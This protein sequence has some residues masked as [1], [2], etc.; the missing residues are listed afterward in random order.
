M[1]DLRAAILRGA[2]AVPRAGSAARGT[3]PGDGFVFSQL[4][5]YVEGDDPRRIDH[6]ATARAGALQTR[7][8][9]EETRLV[10]AAILDQSASMHVGRRRPLTQAGKE[11]L[12]SW[13]DIAEHDDA[14]V[15]IV[16][17]RV[18]RDRRAA[19]MIDAV[20]PGTVSAALTIALRALPSGASLLLVTDGFDEPDDD[21][22]ARAGKRFDATVL[23]ARDPWFD[24]LALRGIV[25]V[26]DAESGR[27][28]GLFIGARERRRY[29]AASA[30]RA[31]LLHERYAAA[32]WRPGTLTEDD[33]RA[34]LFRA[35]GL[36]A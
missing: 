29:A 30:R 33:G 34:S 15:R 28:R 23:L 1:N 9:H 19:P 24:G 13:F 20:R 31:T 17:E 35:F 2:R 36:R 6:A 11:A 10:L 22:L 7:V 26:R 18:V 27:V 16:D 32:G 21:L 14:T 12:R 5:A 8:Y 25:R 4:R 3:R